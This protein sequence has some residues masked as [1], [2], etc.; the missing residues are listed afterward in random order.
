MN[1]YKPTQLKY[2]RYNN[3][4]VKGPVLLIRKDISVMSDL[5]RIRILLYIRPNLKK[6]SY[7]I[8]ILL[9]ICGTHLDKKNNFKISTQCFSPAIN[10]ELHIAVRG[11]T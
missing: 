7:K 4:T 11:G 1:T 10:T 3:K 5:F 8:I 2:E 6:R 9:P